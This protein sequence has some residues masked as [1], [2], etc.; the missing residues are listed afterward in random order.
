MI[1]SRI[2]IEQYGDRE[3]GLLSAI[4]LSYPTFVIYI[5]SPADT[6]IGY[7]EWRQFS[8]RFCLKDLPDTLTTFGSARQRSTELGTA[9][10]MSKRSAKHAHISLGTC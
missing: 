1:R 2:G 8:D 6:G 9:L 4:L 7:A 10:T 5:E 3:R